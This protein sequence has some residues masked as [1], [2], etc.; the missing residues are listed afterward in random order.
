MKHLTIAAALIAGAAVLS[1]VGAETVTYHAT[2]SGASEVPPVTTQGN[3]TAQATLDT[4]SKMLTYTVTYSGLSGPATAGHIHG[5]AATGE[6]AGVMIPFKPPLTSPIKGTATLTD[7]Q[8]RDLE[9]G[10]TY[11]NIHTAAH[12]A[13][14]IRGQLTK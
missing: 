8:M 13:G 14:E 12:P 9:A 3:G 5:P 10:K 11:V 6:N 2:L 1:P 4:A 7:A